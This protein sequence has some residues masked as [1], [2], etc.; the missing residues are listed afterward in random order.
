MNIDSIIKYYEEEIKRLK[1]KF[2]EPQHDLDPIND[3]I[4]DKINLIS[5]FITRLNVLKEMDK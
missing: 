5:G 2:K 1:S 3:H 4:S